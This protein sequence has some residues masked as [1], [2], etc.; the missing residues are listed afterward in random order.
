MS[1]KQ[2]LGSKYMLGLMSK[3]SDGFHE[4][5]IDQPKGPTLVKDYLNIVKETRTRWHALV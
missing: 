2:K 5:A 4:I 1:M 3:L